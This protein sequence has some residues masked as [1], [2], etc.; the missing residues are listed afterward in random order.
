MGNVVS[1]FLIAHKVRPVVPDHVFR[2][3]KIMNILGL[4]NLAV[5]MRDVQV[6][7]VDLVLEIDVKIMKIALQVNIVLESIS[8]CVATTGNVDLRHATQKRKLKVKLV[9]ELQLA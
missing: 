3:V 8:K 1:F 9:S 2:D 6:C 7:V 4:M 5:V